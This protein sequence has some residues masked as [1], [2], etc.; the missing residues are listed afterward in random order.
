M[1]RL[2]GRATVLLL[3]PGP[4]LAVLVNDLAVQRTLFLLAGLLVIR[5]RLGIC[6]LGQAQRLW[7]PLLLA[8]GRLGLRHEVHQLFGCL[9]IR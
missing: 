3:Q 4:Q 8:V 6:K 2:W 1:C 5:G 7:P 9:T